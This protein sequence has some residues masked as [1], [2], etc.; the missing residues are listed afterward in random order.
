MSGGDAAAAAQ[1]YLAAAAE[2]ATTA[3]DTAKEAA[4]IFNGVFRDPELRA[5]LGE[6][7]QHVQNT[8]RMAMDM[9]QAPVDQVAH[10]LGSA[11]CVART[12]VQH[13]VQSAA[14]VFQ[15]QVETLQAE[16]R[17]GEQL[18]SEA[19]Q[20]MQN[21]AQRPPP[22]AAPLPIGG[23]HRRRV[24]SSMAVTRHAGGGGRRAA[25]RKRFWKTR[26]AVTK[27]VRFAL[28]S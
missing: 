2:A 22:V 21:F 13:G 9:L 27:R 3:T 26:K 14:K 25:H 4:H 7:S 19:M 10:L 24:R 15:N 11:S 8:A 6:A 17:R 28:N 20:Q 5:E 23:G 16:K 12:E 1:P 18:A